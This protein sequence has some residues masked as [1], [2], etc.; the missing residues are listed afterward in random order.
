MFNLL[1]TIT[2]HYAATV[3]RLVKLISAH[4]RVLSALLNV[5]NLTD[6]GIRFL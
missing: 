1:A 4:S 3:A 6:L 2:P 5:Q